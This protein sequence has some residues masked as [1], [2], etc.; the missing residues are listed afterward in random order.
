MNVKRLSNLN[1]LNFAFDFLIVM[2]V[3]VWLLE[4]CI[5][6]NIGKA[7]VNL[8][9]NKPTWQKH[10]YLE[11]PWG[12]N[13]AVDGRYSNLS[14]HGGQCAISL[15][16]ETA[17]W[18]V[19]LGDKYSI[20][21]IRLHYAQGMNPWG[22][23]NILTAVFL[24]FSVY[25]S[26]TT[27][28]ENGV[29]CFRDTTYTKSTIPNPVNVTCPYHGRYVIYFNNRT[30]HPYPTD[31]SLHAASDLC[32]VQVYGCRAKGVYGEKC[33]VKCP[34]NCQEGNCD[35]VNGFCLGCVPGFRGHRCEIE[36][37]DDRYGLQCSEK[38]G[39]C[40]KGERCD[41]VTGVCS[42]GCD[43]GRKGTKCDIVSARD[44]F[45]IFSLDNPLTIP[46][47]T[48]FG[49]CSFSLALVVCL[50][51]KKKRRTR[52]N[53]NGIMAVNPSAIQDNEGRTDHKSE[54]HSED[55]TELEAVY[56]NDDYESLN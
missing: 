8:A 38:C 11:K 34:Q 21:H 14:Q 41:H 12:S 26:N 55:Y 31:Y 15:N 53:D 29:L 54:N 9:L 23:N 28:K 48:I 51:F 25:I 35:I 47:L 5:L 49:I 40:K 39:A 52:N 46:L 20:Y 43:D 19:D 17:E 30:H 44:I 24:G 56:Q 16:R 37:P 10:P 7:Y 2:D 4:F 42:N 32:E 36:C 3:T 22:I 1:F 6:V 45:S 33:S 13:L 27:D 18:R 50:C